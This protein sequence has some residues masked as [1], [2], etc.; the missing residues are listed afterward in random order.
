MWVRCPHEVV[1]G[2]S[3]ELRVTLA[4]CAIKEHQ[5]SMAMPHEAD[6]YSAGYLPRHVLACLCVTTR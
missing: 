5:S 6:N 4:P 2:W 1:L 3:P